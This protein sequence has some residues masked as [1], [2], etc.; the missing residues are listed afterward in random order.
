V[1][2]I[3]IEAVTPESGRA[4]YNALAAFEPEFDTDEEGTWCFVS[5]RFSSDEHATKVLATIQRHL[6][7]RGES[8]VSSTTVT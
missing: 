1:Q 5:V 4:L 3:T 7:E 2:T 6:A 8:S